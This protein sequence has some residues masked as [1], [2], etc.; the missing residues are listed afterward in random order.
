LIEAQR[1][2]T[3]IRCELVPG[4][5]AIAGRRF[6]RRRRT[7]GRKDRECRTLWIGQHRE[8][9]D[10]RN[11]VRRAQ[12]L[13]AEAARDIN[14]FVDIRRADIEQPVWRRSLRRCLAR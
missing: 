1:R 2:F 13:R 3:V 7:R 4:K 8:A 9:P 5:L 14:R 6:E 11:V 12:Y 10:R